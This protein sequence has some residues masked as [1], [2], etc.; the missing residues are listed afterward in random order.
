MKLKVKE[1]TVTEV[2]KI[3]VLVNDKESLLVLCDRIAPGLSD[4]ILEFFVAK[5]ELDPELTK[6]LDDYEGPDED[7]IAGMDNEFFEDEGEI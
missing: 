3:P 1:I 4:A 6:Q 2:K 5:D 7:N